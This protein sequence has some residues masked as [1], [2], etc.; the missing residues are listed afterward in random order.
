M[1]CNQILGQVSRNNRVL[2]F[3]DLLH[4]SLLARITDKGLIVDHIPKSF[5]SVIQI[6]NY[7]YIINDNDKD[8]I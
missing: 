5:R 3:Y 4:A 8:F 1:R 7:I 2:F 6:K